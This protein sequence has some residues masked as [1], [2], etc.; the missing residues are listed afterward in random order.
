LQN[1][2]CKGDDILKKRPIIL[3]SLLIVATTYVEF[4]YA[5]RAQGIL[6]RTARAVSVERDKR[7]GG[8][9]DAEDTGNQRQITSMF[10]IFNL[11]IYICICI[12]ITNT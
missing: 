6:L 2:P 12:H 5:Q 11:Y 1:Q 3:R 9:T 7:S 10:L 4:Y 8:C